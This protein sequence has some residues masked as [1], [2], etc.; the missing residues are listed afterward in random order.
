MLDELS[1]ITIN[2]D[3]RIQDHTPGHT[4][5]CCPDKSHD[6]YK[7]RV[8]TLLQGAGEGR[9][10]P[11]LGQLLEQGCGGVSL[12]RISTFMGNIFITA[13]SKIWS[14]FLAP[15]LVNNRVHLLYL[16]TDSRILKLPSRRNNVHQQICKVERSLFAR[17][18]NALEPSINDD[19]EFMAQQASIEEESKRFR[20]LALN[21]LNMSLRHLVRMAGATGKQPELHTKYNAKPL[22]REPR[23]STPSNALDQLN[24]ITINERRLVAKV[25]ART[26]ARSRESSQ[27]RSG[28]RAVEIFHVKMYVYTEHSSIFPTQDWNSPS[29]LCRAT[30]SSRRYVCHEF[31]YWALECAC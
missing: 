1:S 19:K 14:L 21:T 7:S 22:Q 13:C 5:R 20:D 2:K 15:H 6:Y 11:L 16:P 24:S 29:R 31:C 18:A 28:R 23:R 8:C 30:G 9:A 4:K 27:V 17:G 25:V 3:I 10:V 26:G 12:G